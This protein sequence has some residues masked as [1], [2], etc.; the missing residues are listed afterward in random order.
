MG[1]VA[2]KLVF[3]AQQEIEGKTMTKDMSPVWGKGGV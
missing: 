1:E 2:S 3:T